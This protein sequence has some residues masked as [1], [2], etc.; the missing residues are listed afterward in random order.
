MQ[1]RYLFAV[2]HVVL[3]KF[4][5]KAQMETLTVNI[6]GILSSTKTN[7]FHLSPPWAEDV[8]RWR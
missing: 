3:R 2:D 5:T 1:G 6:P 4:L 8:A 7:T